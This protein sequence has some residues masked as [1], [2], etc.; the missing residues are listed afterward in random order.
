M[1]DPDIVQF[2]HNQHFTIISTI[3]KKGYPHNSCKGIVEIDK[4]GKAYLLDLYMAGTYENLKNNPAISITAVDEHKFAGYCLKGRAKIVP[5]NKVNRRIL[6][7][8][9]DKIASRISHRLLKNMRGEK[10]HAAHPEAL[11]PMPTYLIAVDVDEIID[12]VP[13]HIKRKA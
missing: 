7:L 3:D 1:L 6:T 5:K 9:E 4:S 13:G 10:G 11:L 8:W 2:F 12:L